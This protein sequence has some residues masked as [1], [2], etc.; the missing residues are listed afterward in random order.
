MA[1]QHRFSPVR[2]VPRRILMLSALCLLILFAMSLYP[3]SADLIPTLQ[4][5]TYLG[6]TNGEFGEAIALD[7]DGNIYVTGTTASADFPATNALGVDGP[8]IYVTKFDPTASTQLFSVFLGQGKSFDIAVDADGYVYVTG[9]ADSFPTVQAIQPA[10]AGMED[11][12]IAKINPT[13]TALVY[14]TYLGG[15]GNDFALGLALDAARNVYVVGVTDSTNFPTYNAYQSTFGG[16]Q[17]DFFVARLNASGSALVYSTY[18]GGDDYDISMDIAVDSAGNAY[19]TGET[20]SNNFP[21][22]NAFQPAHANWCAHP[23]NTRACTDA[24]LAKLSPAGMPIFSTYLGGNGNYERGNAITVDQL[25]SAYVAGNT[26][27]ID[28]PITANAFQTNPGGNSPAFVAKFDPDGSG[29][30]YS[31]YLGGTTDGSLVLDIELDADHNIVVGGATWATDFPTV[32]PIQ[33]TKGGAVGEPDAFVS[34]LS[35]D[36]MNLEFSTY[37]GGRYAEYVE[38]SP[39]IALDSAGSVY[40]TGSTY[41]DDFPVLE[42]FQPEPGAP[43]TGFSNA[44]A[45]L[46]KIGFRFVPHAEP[47]QAA[48]HNYFTTDTP[49]LTWTPVTWATHYHVQVSKDKFFKGTPDFE[50]VT[51]GSEPFMTTDSDPLDDGLYYWRVQTQ[52]A[53]GSYGGW[54]PVES[55][56]VDAD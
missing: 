32:N 17:W 7:K 43:M 9:Q 12:F 15:A 26:D 34:R 35:A 44:D 18:Y 20:G 6:G 29:L 53:D 21:V 23:P 13:G 51:A 10:Q 27:S 45:F 1:A 52:K 8:G 56:T 38:F 41:S 3:A 22:V 25:G 55:F 48:T 54:S 31:T 19:I 5:S 4:F 14:A 50:G 36:G 33:A 39:H 47:G 42:A 16:G 30:L 46:I 28:F 24:Y 49:T 40:M 37:F 2:F 11:A